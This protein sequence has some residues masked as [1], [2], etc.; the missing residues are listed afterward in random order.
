MLTV[1]KILLSG[2]GV[3]TPWQEDKHTPVTDLF[4]DWKNR[5]KMGTFFL[6]P[7]YILIL[8]DITSKLY[9]SDY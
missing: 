2:D 4:A 7:Y 3:A 1:V 8:P 9:L 6:L 5:G